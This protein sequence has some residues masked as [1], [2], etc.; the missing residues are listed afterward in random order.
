MT[1]ERVRHR[2]SLGE[3][4]T[5]A[6]YRKG[7]RCEACKAANTRQRRM[8]RAR[9]KQRGERPMLTLVDDTQAEPPQTTE[10]RTTPP[11]GAV[12]DMEAAVVTDLIAID[13]ANPEKGMTYN[14]LR[15]AAI[16][17]AREIDSADSTSKAPLVKQLLEVMSKLT[18]KDGD[19]DP[20]AFLAGLAD[21]FPSS[22]GGDDSET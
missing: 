15:A 11:S 4:G 1:S 19:D 6:A 7:C 20:L 18:G 22:T 9:A 14:T 12:G 8:D 16:A 2:P 5:V 21:E 17:L 10:P 3:R 13:N